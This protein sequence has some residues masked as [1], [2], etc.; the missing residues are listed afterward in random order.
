MAPWPCGYFHRVSMIG[1]QEE[2]FSP[3]CSPGWTSK[4]AYSTFNG[5]IIMATIEWKPA[6][7]V[8]VE[9]IDE[10]HRQLLQL[11]EDVI[12]QL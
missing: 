5:G 8:G 7:S 3:V 4:M 9:Q 1:Y 10:Q 6:Y 11:I 12:R 2:S